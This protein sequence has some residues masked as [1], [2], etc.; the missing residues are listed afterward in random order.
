MP[1]VSK[2]ISDLHDVHIPADSGG[3]VQAG[4]GEVLGSK[5]GIGVGDW[6]DANPQ[7]HGEQWSGLGRA[8][9]Q[10]LGTNNIGDGPFYLPFHARPAA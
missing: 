6:I 5:S 2:L 3:S 4:I 8:S 9:D 7:G 1:L 10:I